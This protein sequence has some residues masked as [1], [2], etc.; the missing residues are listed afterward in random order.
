[1]AGPPLCRAPTGA[2]RIARLGVAPAR[3][4]GVALPS[5]APPLPRPL[6]HPSALHSQWLAMESLPR[7][8][9]PA[10]RQHW[11]YSTDGRLGR[12]RGGFSLL[13]SVSEAQDGGK[14]LVVMYWELRCGLDR[15]ASSPNCK[16]LQNAT[17]RSDVP[18]CAT[19]K[20]TRFA[21]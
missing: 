6:P 17:E 19:T 15:Q 11:R 20:A 16:Q 13:P 9:L 7:P 4:T 18:M 10:T 5:S 14:A 1:M 2:R 21:R 3:L 12:P 8:P